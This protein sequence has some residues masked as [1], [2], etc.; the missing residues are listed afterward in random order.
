MPVA[1]STEKVSDFLRRFVRDLL[2]VHAAL[3]GHHEGDAAGGAVDEKRQIE[4]LLDFGAFF[5]IDA[6]DLLSGRAGLQRHQRVAEHLDR[7]GTDVD[8]G[9]CEAHAAPGAGR[10]FL[11]PA[12]AATAGMDLRL[13]DIDRAGKLARRLGGFFYRGGGKALRNRY[14]EGPQ[15]FLGLVLMDVHRGKP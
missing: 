9:F 7:I 5:H 11:E 2:D 13:H 3:G 4:L 14:A 6:V 8:K 1:G 12:L 10:K 15:H